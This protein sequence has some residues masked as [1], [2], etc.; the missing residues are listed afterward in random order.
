MFRALTFAARGLGRI[1][2]SIAKGA[3]Q[4]EPAD[5]QDR[6][7][8]RSTR[9]DMM[10]SPNERYYAEQYWRIMSSYLN[11]L[12]RNAKVLDLGC[13]QGRFSVRLGELFAEGNVVC[14]DISAEAISQAKGYAAVSNVGN[15]EFHVRSVTD[16][17]VDATENDADAIL[18]TEVGIFYP[19]WHHDL[20]RISKTLKPGGIIMISVRPQY[21]DALCLIK[22]RMWTEV[23]T[24]MTER[25]GR[26]FGP[27]LVFTWQTSSE[28]RSLLADSYGFEVLELFGVGVCSG[29]PG[30]PH[31]SICEPVVVSS[32]ER[33]LLMQTELEL[34]KSFPDGGRYILAVARKPLDGSRSGSFEEPADPS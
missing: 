21:F 24:V 13:G 6:G 28:L 34:G 26:I 11:Q 20:S 29:I 8:I 14:C 12:P 22:D 23:R 4:W 3:R 27:S 10:T 1:S 15:V 5:L 18:F 7:V 33:E 2:R 19:G 31:A 16:L 9:Y 30:D 25:Q 32:E 17:L